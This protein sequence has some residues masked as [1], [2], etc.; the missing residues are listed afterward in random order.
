MAPWLRDTLSGGILQ[1]RDVKRA[2]RSENQGL[3]DQ[4]GAMRITSAASAMILRITLGS[5]ARGGNVQKPWW[6]GAAKGVCILRPQSWVTGEEPGKLR[7][8]W[9]SEQVH[10]RLSEPETD[11]FEE[12]GVAIMT[13]PLWFS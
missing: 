12:V 8:R 6:P 9:R 11:G 1:G 7:I 5:R 2:T 10:L 4:W 3:R 13:A